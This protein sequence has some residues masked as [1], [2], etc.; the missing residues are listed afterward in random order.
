MGLYQRINDG[1]FVNKVPF[2]NRDAFR[3]ERDRLNTLFRQALREEFG[4]GLSQK[5]LDEVETKSYYNMK[6][7][8][9]L[10]WAQ[11]YEELADFALTVLNDCKNETGRDYFIRNR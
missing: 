4:S 7:E 1:E 5:I 2:E 11:N 9:L 3:A 8:G 6:G 10:G